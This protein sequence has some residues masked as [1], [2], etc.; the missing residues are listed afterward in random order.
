MQPLSSFSIPIVFDFIYI[1][2]VISQFPM[3]RCP[4]RIADA[5]RGENVPFSPLWATFRSWSASLPSAHH[6]RRPAGINAPKRTLIPVL[7]HRLHQQIAQCLGRPHSGYHVTI[8]LPHRRRLA[9][10]PLTD[11]LRIKPGISVAV[12]LASFRV[13]LPPFINLVLCLWLPFLI[14][15]FSIRIIKIL[16]GSC[17]S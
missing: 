2:N 12:R 16:N 7:F 11:R 5:Q 9:V 15:P 1:V 6:K 14:S 3:Q 4:R 13:L 8:L 10:P 17:S